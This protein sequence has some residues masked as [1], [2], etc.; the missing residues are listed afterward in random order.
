MHTSCVAC[1]CEGGASLTLVAFIDG[2]DAGE[3]GLV[4]VLR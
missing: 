1:C 4:T 3:A 2:M